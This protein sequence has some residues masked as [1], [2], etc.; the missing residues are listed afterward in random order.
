MSRSY[1]ALGLCFAVAMLACEVRAGNVTIQKEEGKLRYARI[2]GQ[3]QNPALDEAARRQTSANQ[4]IAQLEANHAR[5]A[6]TILTNHLTKLFFSGLSDPSTLRYLN[7]T[8]GE[9]IFAIPR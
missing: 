7:Q 5:Q 4:S 9:D 2:E 8:L 6:D 3:D 1:S